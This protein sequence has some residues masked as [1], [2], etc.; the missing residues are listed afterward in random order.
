MRL[1][2]TIS[3]KVQLEGDVRSHLNLPGEQLCCLAFPSFHW[4]IKEA[5]CFFFFF[6][7]TVLHCKARSNQNLQ[8]NNLL[9]TRY[10]VFTR[11]LCT[12][13]N[14][15]ISWEQQC[16]VHYNAMPLQ[17]CC[18]SRSVKEWNGYKSWEWERKNSIICMSLCTVR[19]TFMAKKRS[20]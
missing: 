12:T 4:P 16:A 13:A 15:H 3:F 2:R 11:M 20:K 7:C 5:S 18:G 17:L 10:Q 14:V 19:F 6:C 9:T 8:L 1:Q